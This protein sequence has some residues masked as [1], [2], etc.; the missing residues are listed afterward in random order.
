MALREPCL[1]VIFNHKFDQNI[2]KIRRI[3]KN[4][5]N[6]I[7]F[8]VPFYDG[9]DPFVISIY[10]SSDVFSLFISQ[11]YPKLK[12]IDSPFFVFIGD[13]LLLNKNIDSQNITKKL[14]INTGS[15]YIKYIQNIA[16]I[17][18]CNWK[19]AVSAIL[20]TSQ[21]CPKSLYIN[22]NKEL[23]SPDEALSCFNKHGISTNTKITI[24]NINLITILKEI[25]KRRVFLSPNCQGA[26]LEKIVYDILRYGYYKIQ[27]PLAFSYSDFFV[28]PR[29]SLQLFSHYCGIFGAWDIF[30]EIA[31]PT[32]LLLSCDSIVFENIIKGYEIWDRDERTRF[33][34]EHEDLGS[35]FSYMDAHNLLYIHPIKLSKLENLC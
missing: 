32:S 27:Y 30:V 26:M 29:E 35:I 16:D 31:I 3:Y 33:L 10:A 24:K 6:T 20:K 12:E 19:H 17:N 8:L 7:F 34:Q 2:E 22:I 1:V 15:A 25:I 21:R 23:P 11:A 14:N 18:I 4:R 13:D 5:F 28:I 9:D